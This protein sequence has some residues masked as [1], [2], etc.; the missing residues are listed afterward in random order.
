MIIFTD[1][2]CKENARKDG[3]ALG[4]GGWAY[5]ALKQIPGEDMK[6]ALS[7]SGSQEGSTNQEMEIVAVASAL[8]AVENSKIINDPEEVINLYSDS[9]YVINCLKDRWYDK[10]IR[11]G[12]LNSKK[13]PVENRDA[14]E[15]L[16]SA[17]NALTNKHE[18]V[19]FHVKRNSTK[20]IKKVDG[21]AKQ[22]SKK[23][24]S[25]EQ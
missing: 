22:A 10:W 9:A 5:I 13:K 15:R 1:G 3:V 12:W 24:T 11:N 8:E 18:V 4:N 2:A 17:L 21:M 25:Q 20:F 19:F 14:W 6:V 23:G 7:A 16:I